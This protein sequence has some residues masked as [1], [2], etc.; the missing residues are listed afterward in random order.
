MTAREWL[1]KA[2]REGFAIPALNVGTFET[3]KGIVEACLEAKSPVI[4]ESSTGE[5][6]WME[7]ENVAS[8]SRNFAKKYNLV[9]IV[10]L[11]HAYTYE[12]TRPGLAAAYDLIHFDGSKL[13]YEENIEIC[14]KIVPEAQ[15]M[16]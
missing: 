3:F 16:G 4:I 10:N 15:R 11:D 2:K 6:K 13:S 9:I 1:T 14:K 12:D 5:T 8:I 7:S